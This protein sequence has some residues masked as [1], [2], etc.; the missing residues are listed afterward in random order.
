M[1]AAKSAKKETIEISI[2][3]AR[4]L[5]SRP[6]DYKDNSYYEVTE[7]AKSLLRLLIVND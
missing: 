4:L 6:E 7:V 3:L 5:A 2:A 1:P